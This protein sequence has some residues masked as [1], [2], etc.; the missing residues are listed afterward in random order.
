MSKMGRYVFQ[1]QE[2]AR[3]KLYDSDRR[4]HTHA[5]AASQAT[6]TPTGGARA[7][8]ELFCGNGGRESTGSNEMGGLDSPEGKSLP[9][10]ERPI[11][12][13][14]EEMDNGRQRRS[15]SSGACGN[16]GVAN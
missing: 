2:E 8:Q 14:G 7:G 4:Q 5:E 15:V 12:V 1:L 16:E 9:E 6:A 10:G 13:F 11:E 3:R